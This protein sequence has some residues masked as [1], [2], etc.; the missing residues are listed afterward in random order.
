LPFFTWPLLGFIGWALFTGIFALNHY[1]SWKIGRQWLP[2]VL[3]F[4]LVSQI[5]VSST[6]RR[7]ALKALFVSAFLVA[8]LM[9]WGQA[10][11]K[12]MGSGFHV[13]KLEF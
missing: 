10:S 3:L 13:D 2:A 11:R 5:V 12:E 7:Q 6:Q 4:F 1:E 9:K 8:L